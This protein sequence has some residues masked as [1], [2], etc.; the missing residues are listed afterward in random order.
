MR[1]S[2]SNDDNIF[3]TLF[4]K[5]ATLLV[6]AAELLAKIH[7][8][9]PE[10][11]VALRDDLHNLEQQ[12]DEITHEIAERLNQT[13]VTPL[14]RDDIT[15]ISSR[16]DDCMDYM[17]EAG[18]LVVLYKVDELPPG[19]AEQLNVIQRC[20][21]LT[22]QAMPHLKTLG[23]LRDYWVEINRLENDGDQ[24]YRRTISD[25]FESGKDAVEII[26]LKD[27][28]EVLEKAIDSF[29]A[30]AN[31]VEVIAIKES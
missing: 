13:F 16:L 14:D 15:Y 2:R 1:F 11:R 30:L 18:D 29:E 4:T 12:C 23:G 25:L 26:K 17:D 21:D 8:A 28:I 31:G 20:C 22:A 3:F 24:A 27:I 7:G 9:A 6:S 19:V 5:Q 10:R